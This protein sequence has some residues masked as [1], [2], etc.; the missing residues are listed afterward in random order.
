VAAAGVGGGR[1]ARTRRSA[2]GGRDRRSHAR[3]RATHKRE[4]ALSSSNSSGSSSSSSSSNAAAAAAATQQQQQHNAR[5]R[6]R[7]KE[8][9]GGQSAERRGGRGRCGLRGCVLVMQGGG[10]I[11]D[12]CGSRAL[13]RPPNA[14]ERRGGVGGGLA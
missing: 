13:A 3:A 2:T 8:G 14:N 7:L 6:Y 10:G 11:Y 12:M 1:Q 9:A 4:K 5:Q